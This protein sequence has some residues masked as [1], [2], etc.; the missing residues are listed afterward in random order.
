MKRNL[1]FSGPAI[2]LTLAIVLGWVVCFWPARILNPETGVL[3]MSIAAI[4][5]LVPGWI[6]VFLTGL[7][8]FPNELS[9][10]MIQTMVRM[11]SVAGAAVIVRK[12]RPEIGVAD[13]YG[14]LIGFYLLAMTV[15]V[16]MLRRLRDKSN[17]RSNSRCNGPQAEPAGQE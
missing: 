9:A 11:G 10:L 15:E 1:S 8:I 4:C 2:T 14:W 3:W 12:L 5:C 7:A 17:S 16:W 13:F 6:V